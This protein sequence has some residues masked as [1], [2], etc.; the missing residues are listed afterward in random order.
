MK[1]IVRLTESDLTRIVRRVINEQT[2]T[3]EKDWDAI[4]MG[5]VDLPNVQQSMYK[6][7][8]G[9]SSTGGKI[10]Y[11]DSGIPGTAEYKYKLKC[12]CGKLN[13]NETPFCNYNVIGPKWKRF[14]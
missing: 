9:Q 7:H 13:K 12:D 6:T 4:Y 10:I 8:T 3:G 2:A 1:R 5:D 11:G 14:C